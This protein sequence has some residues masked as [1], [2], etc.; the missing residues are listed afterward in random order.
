M[1]SELV[2]ILLCLSMME[3]RG[4]VSLFL[5]TLRIIFGNCFH[6]F[7]RILIRFQDAVF[8]VFCGNFPGFFVCIFCDGCYGVNPFNMR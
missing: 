8:G 7:V 2:S 4:E 3:S 1:T 5:K 6:T